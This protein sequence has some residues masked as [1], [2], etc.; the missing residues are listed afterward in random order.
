V[1]V[2]CVASGAEGGSLWQKH[3]I[4]PVQPADPRIG[5]EP[6]ELAP[7]ELPGGHDGFLCRHINR[8]FA[9]EHLQELGVAQRPRRRLPAAEPGLIQAPH[10]VQQPAVHHG[11]DAPGQPLT[12]HLPVHRQTDLDGRLEILAL[13]HE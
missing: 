9:V 5:P 1:A 10:L 4:L 2:R 8:R 6:G 3:R 7:G 11:V 12:K 13:G